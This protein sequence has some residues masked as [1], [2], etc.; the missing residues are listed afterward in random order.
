MYLTSAL[1]WGKFKRNRK[2]G[3]ALFSSVSVYHTQCV[4][5]KFV[6]VQLPNSV[7]ESISMIDTL[8]NLERKTEEKIS[9]GTATGTWVG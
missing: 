4:S 6:C 9:Q 3:C 8:G 5:H 2:K 7:L 1:Y